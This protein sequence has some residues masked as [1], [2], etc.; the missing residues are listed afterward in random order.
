MRISKG[1]DLRI[2]NSVSGFLFLSIF[3]SPSDDSGSNSHSDRHKRVYPC[4]VQQLHTM[5]DNPSSNTS[6]FRIVHPGIVFTCVSFS[7]CLDV[8]GID[9]GGG[10]LDSDNDLI[11]EDAR[12]IIS[13]SSS[14][15]VEEVMGA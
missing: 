3:S 8:V 12:W 10:T 14:V 1:A 9:F 2:V 4:T 5:A 15:E 6:S 13:S 11:R 7:T